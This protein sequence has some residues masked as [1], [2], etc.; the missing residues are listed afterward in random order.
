MSDSP[1]MM[2]TSTDSG[3]NG[4]NVPVIMPDPEQRSPF[5]QDIFPKSPFGTPIRENMRTRDDDEEHVLYPDSS[6]SRFADREASW[7]RL[8][9]VVL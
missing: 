4:L 6:G 2:S 7:N 9:C 3:A 5:R 1:S 8:K